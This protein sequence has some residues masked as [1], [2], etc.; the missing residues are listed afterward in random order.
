MASGRSSRGAGRN[1]KTPSVRTNLLSGVFDSPE[2]GGGGAAPRQTN[3]E[4]ER[5]LAE[6]RRTEE[7]L[8]RRTA[9]LEEARNFLD[10]VLE[11]APA[12][13]PGPPRHPV[14]LS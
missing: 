8:A 1:R 9:E 3:T 2:P 11:H 12:R 4:L 5:Q 7:T 6:Y 14:S 13:A 10:P